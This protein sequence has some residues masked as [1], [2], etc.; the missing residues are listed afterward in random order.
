MALLPFLSTLLC[1]CFASLAA[2]HGYWAIGGQ[3]G[4]RAALPSDK[5][6]MVLNPGPLACLVVALGLS[7][8]AVFYGLMTFPTWDPLPFFWRS[9]LGWIIVGIFTLR[10]I[11]DRRYIGLTRTV[12]NTAFAQMDRRWYTPLSLMLALFGAVIQLLAQA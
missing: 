1:T 9:V 5:T 10:A 3:W 2:L 4:L 7:G 12:R 6:G 8:M 11:G